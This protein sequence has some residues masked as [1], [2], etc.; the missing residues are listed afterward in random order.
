MNIKYWS[1]KNPVKMFSY[2]TFLKQIFSS[3]IQKGLSQVMFR[4]FTRFLNIFKHLRILGWCWIYLKH[5]WCYRKST[6]LSVC[7]PCQDFPAL[8]N[9]Q[10]LSWGGN[11]LILKILWHS[12][13]ISLYKWWLFHLFQIKKMRS[14]KTFIVLV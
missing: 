12:V 13:L 1:I 10:Y 5:H 2:R 11:I 9:T 3:V 7:L 4:S 8:S 6:G 14:K